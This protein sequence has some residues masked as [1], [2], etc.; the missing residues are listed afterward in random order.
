MSNRWE[1]LAGSGGASSV[2]P[3]LNASRIVKDV[4]ANGTVVRSENGS[5]KLSGTPLTDELRALVKEHKDSILQYLSPKEQ[6]PDIKESELQLLGDDA[7]WKDFDRASIAL[8]R[9][10]RQG[11]RDGMKQAIKTLLAISPE[12][13]EDR[14][15][16]R[17]IVNEV[18]QREEL[19]F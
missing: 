3:L 12:D 2:L 1:K 10:W 5:L 6:Y 4:E 19:P 18:R 11:K 9:I 13:T 16:E 7:F 14:P 15:A 17:S 8:T